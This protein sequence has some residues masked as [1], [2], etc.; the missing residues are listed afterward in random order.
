MKTLLFLLLSGFISTAVAKEGPDDITGI[1][2]NQS[3]KGQI[4]IYK[5]GE[6]Y[7]GKIIW[8]KEPNNAQGNPKLDIKNPRVSL[9]N[10]PILGAV[11]LRD[12]SFKNEEWSGGYVYDPANGKEYKCYM[13]LKDQK[14][15]SV[16]GYIGISLL[17]R[18]EE[19]T[20]MR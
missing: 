9:Q 10:R 18:T 6:K 7:F 20:R 5:E 2:M 11:I 14:T 12:F 15:L 19:W 3:G 16:R 8:L 13:K 4:Q 1:W 17:G